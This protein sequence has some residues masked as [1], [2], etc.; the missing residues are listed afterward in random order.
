LAATGHGIGNPSF[1]MRRDN[2]TATSHWMSGL[3]RASRANRR[4]SEIRIP[5]LF[6]VI[7]HLL[8]KFGFVQSAVGLILRGC[9]PKFRVDCDK[10]WQDRRREVWLS[11]VLVNR[12]YRTP[13]KAASRRL[14]KN[15]S[16]S[17]TGYL[18]WR[19][20][21]GPQTGPEAAV[22]AAL[23]GDVTVPEKIA[24]QIWSR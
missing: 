24:K 3:T 2:F 9:L 16:G 20:P 23:L 8:S 10:Q 5:G 18:T 7:E 19:V 6:P 17:H 22:C 15:G 1:L 11:L 12:S 13:R 14:H 21:A 4:R